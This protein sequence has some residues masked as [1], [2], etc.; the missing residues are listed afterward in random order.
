ML[1]LI[2]RQLSE[3]QVNTQWGR[4]KCFMSIQSERKQEDRHGDCC[5]AVTSTSLQRAGIQQ[6]RRD[7]H[8]LWANEHSLSDGR[9]HYMVWTRKRIHYK[10][11]SQICTYIFQSSS[12]TRFSF[13][14]VFFPTVPAQQWFLFRF[15]K[16]KA[17]GNTDSYQIIFW[18]YQN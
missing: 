4:T 6:L 1:H 15:V 12:Y 8:E 2:G 10:I 17:W 13:R 3:W 11:Q 16:L 9:T 18:F 7:A 5:C 14:F